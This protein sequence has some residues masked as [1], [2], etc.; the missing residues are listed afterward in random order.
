M[1]QDSRSYQAVDR[2]AGGAEEEF[3]VE[4]TYYVKE[5]E[6]TPEEKRRKC[7]S[8]TLPIIIA[9]FVVGGFVLYIFS[10]L[11]MF[12]YRK[13]RTINDQSLSCPYQTY[14]EALRKI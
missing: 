7:L 4:K 11:H 3:D 9:V 13:I 1:S 5:T 2:A 6:L 8:C 10:N 12:T 14:A